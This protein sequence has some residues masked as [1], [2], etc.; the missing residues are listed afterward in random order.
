MR[1][2]HEMKPSQQQGPENAPGQRRTLCRR[3]RQ[4]HL[5]Q[6]LDHHRLSIVPRPEQHPRRHRACR[7]AR[8]CDR[9][10]ERLDALRLV[11]MNARI[12]LLKL[13]SSGRES[14][15]F[16]FLERWSRLTSAATVRR[17]RRLPGA[18]TALS[19]RWSSSFSL[20]SPDGPRLERERNSR[21]QR[22]ALL[23]F[24]T[25]AVKRLTLSIPKSE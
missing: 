19:A 24:V 4:G 22:S 8:E 15:P 7:G 5:E 14:A 17:R 25:P 23:Q 20:F 13:R 6:Q 18:R 3:R 1:T 2:R 9:A 12:K 10:S 11:P 21:T 16:E